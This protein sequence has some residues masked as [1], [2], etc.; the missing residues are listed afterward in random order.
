MEVVSFGTYNIRNGGN[1][2]LKSAL[3][4]M[5]QANVDL[6]LLK[7]TNIMGGY[8]RGSLRD[9]VLSRRNSKTS[10]WGRG[11]LLQRVSVICGGDP[12]T[13]QPERH[14]LPVGYGQAML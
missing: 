9:I 7:E 4:G 1:G 2:G 3:H 8:T 6:G 13:A 11:T 14:Q 5:S 10:P 12:P